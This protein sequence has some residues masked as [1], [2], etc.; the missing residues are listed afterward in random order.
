MERE[1]A[2]LQ[3]EAAAA[4]AKAEEFARKMAEAE[5]ATAFLE[6]L[7]FV[8]TSP[9]AGERQGT[10]FDG[11]MASLIECY[12]T[13]PQSGFRKIGYKTQEAYKSSLRRIDNDLGKERIADLDQERLTRQYQDWTNGET[14]H[15][16][17]AHALAAQLRI[18]AAF[19]AT[20]LKDPSCREL[21]VVLHYMKFKKAE[22]QNAPMTA[23]QAVAIRNK[24]REMGWPSLALAQAL[25]FDFKLSQRQVIGEWLPHKH[26]G[27]SEFHTDRLKWVN[28]LRWNDLDEICVL[29]PASM[30]DQRFDLLSAPMVRAE[31]QAMFCPNGEPLTRA[32]LPNSTRPM[33][34]YERAELPYQ[35]H[36]FRTNW[37]KVAE[38]AKI[39]KN[40]RNRDSRIGAREVPKSDLD[41]GKE[42]VG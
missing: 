18:L 32:R 35:A 27:T 29:R 38:A 36:Q 28:G 19:G 41:I 25:Q 22:S 5:R 24:A 6:E 34:I 10:A 30:P 15:I 40:V 42:S 23:D 11:R 31:L 17:L 9:P 8:V 7:G 20:V 3:E 13:H 37:A 39:P 4:A 2:R 26:P 16:A 33:I 21:R 14:S 1:N 12:K